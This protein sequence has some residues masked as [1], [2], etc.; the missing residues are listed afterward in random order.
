MQRLNNA[1]LKALPGRAAYSEELA[2]AAGEKADIAS[3]GGGK[4]IPEENQNIRG[5]RSRVFVNNRALGTQ[6][7][8][9]QQE[10]EDARGDPGE[11]QYQHSLR[12]A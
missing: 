5:Q 7:K 9:G 3:G 2:L 12:H 4:G 6:D 8:D 11:T 10:Q 1:D